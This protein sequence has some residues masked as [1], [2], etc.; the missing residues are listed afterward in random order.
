[1]SPY[2]VQITD[3]QILESARHIIEQEGLDELSLAH[4]ATNLGIKAPSLYKHFASKGDLLKAL[5]TVTLVELVAVMS[6]V[7]NTLTPRARLLEMA[8]KY[9]IFAHA[10]PTLYSLAFAHIMPNTRPDPTLLEQLA[11]PLQASFAALVGD[12]KALVGLR[13]AW[14]L[15][16]GFVMLE[17]NEQFQRGGDLDAVFIQTL[18]AYLDGW[19]YTG[20]RL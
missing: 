7:D 1:M 8:R 19:E 13:G 15:L 20:G 11:L 6:Q 4:L 2:P 12:E 9:R 5:I 14:A 18:N 3:D 17:L 10:H 16:H